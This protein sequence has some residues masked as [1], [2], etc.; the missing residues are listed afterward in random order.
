MH[1]KTLEVNIV[2]LVKANCSI[3]EEQPAKEKGLLPLKVDIRLVH[4]L[5]KTHIKIMKRL[6]VD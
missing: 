3:K 5:S 1:T 6:K 2:M 4:K